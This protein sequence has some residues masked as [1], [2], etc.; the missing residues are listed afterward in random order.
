MSLLAAYQFLTLLPIKRNF[1]TR[2]IARSTVFFPVVGLSIGL[3]LAAVNWVLGLI[4][5][6]AAVNVLLV[7]LMALCHGGLHLD[8]VADT[9]DGA[10]GH[11]TVE[12][13]LEIMRD[14]RIGGFGAI[15]LVM[16]ILMEYVF[17]NTIPADIKWL[18]LIAAPL[19]SRWLMAYAIY[20]FPY[21]R[22]EGLGK[23]FKDGVTNGQFVPATLMT[24]VALGV[25]WGI[26]GLILAVGAWLV[27]SL[28]ALYLKRLLGGLTGDCYGALNEVATLSVFLGVII[29]AHNNWWIFIPGW[30]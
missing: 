30:A 1:T 7:V 22:P 15:G 13:R 4:L 28:V 10:A 20:A 16:V 18:A 24:L 17:L 29:M 27:V 8:G 3:L 21:A 6:N 25:L 5:P 11:R 14:S 23:A 26:S 9:M 2:Q 12:R 19:T